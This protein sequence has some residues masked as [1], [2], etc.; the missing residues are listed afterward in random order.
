M[1]VVQQ[2]EWQLMQFKAAS[3]P[4]GVTPETDEFGLPVAAPRRPPEKDEV[5]ERMRRAAILNETGALRMAIKSAQRAG[6][7]EEAIEEATRILTGLENQ[8]LM[9][10]ALRTKD[11]GKLETIVSK[12]SGTPH[13]HSEQF[14]QAKKILSQ[15]EARD[16]LSNAIKNKDEEELLA[17]IEKARNTGVEK[18]KIEKA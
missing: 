4:R 5:I 17:A 1:E 6:G 10:A 3:G 18:P 15:F 12:V 9:S 7:R 11:R 8:K 16:A 14:E 2:A 13:E